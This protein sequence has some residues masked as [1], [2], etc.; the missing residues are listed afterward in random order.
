MRRWPL[1]LLLAALLT[2]PG[3]VTVHP[4]PTPPARVSPATTSADHKQPAGPR[5]AQPD[6][7]PGLP[8][9]RL[10][11]PPTTPEHDRAPTPARRMPTRGA[12][13]ETRHARP[14]PRRRTAPTKYA[15]KPQPRKAKARPPHTPAYPG[16]PATGAGTADM[17]ALCRAT[18]GVTSTAI[19]ALCHQTY[20]R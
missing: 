20:G 17:T 9:S 13:D 4:A 19:A 2:A 12:S 7:R 18:H 10:P 15:A 6:T 8:L 11:E 5:P 3:C 14:A 16:R 1:P